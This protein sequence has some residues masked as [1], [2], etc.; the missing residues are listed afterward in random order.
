M[1]KGRRGNPLYRIDRDLIQVEEAIS[2]ISGVERYKIRNLAMAVGL[3][4]V[5]AWIKMVGSEEFDK[6]YRNVKG[7]VLEFVEDLKR[8]TPQGA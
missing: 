1:V 7:M 5:T 2:K 8:R 4:V 3:L 6:I